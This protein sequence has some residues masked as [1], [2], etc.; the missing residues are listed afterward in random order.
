MSSIK[1]VEIGYKPKVEKELIATFYMEP[2]KV[3]FHE[4]ADA[5]AGES[6]IGS[7]TEL[8]T[9]SPKTAV[10]LKARVFY[11]NEKK[12]IIK[13][14][15]PM[16]LFEKGSIPQL[17]SSLGGNIFGMKA[18]KNLRWQDIE[19]PKKYIDSFMGPAFGI[20]GIRKI[21]KVK[22]R[23]LLGS[24]IKPKVGLSALAQ[25][26]LSA[27]VWLNGI[28]LI[29]DDENLTDM[30]FNRF[31]DRVKKVF[32]WKRKVEKET[33]QEKLYACNITAT[34]D[35]MLRRAKLVKKYGGRCVMI[36]LVSVGLDNVQYLR[37][38]K[39]GLIIHGHRAGHAMFT[40]YK[41]HGMSMLVLAKL[42][43]L[44][45]ID[46]LHTGTV[47]G[48][49]EGNEEEVMTVNNL[50]KEDWAA[51]NVV[52]EDW[53]NIKPVMPIAS[54]GLHPGLLPKLI[55][56]LGQDLIVNFGAGIHGHPDGSAAGARACYQ[57]AEAISKG[58]DL[59]KYAE[60]HVE[61]ARA[62]EYWKS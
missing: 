37:K 61:L 24:I 36:D 26:K 58:I 28:D 30:A 45:G 5:V 31:E 11:I 3:K 10:R 15:Y 59:K 34:P 29:K 50:L 46:Q 42:S 8:K 9:L 17:L 22:N 52:R 19:F 14:A 6:S 20:E 62:L 32:E 33:K 16:D 13:I 25:A 1:F 38:Q 27:V 21:L 44:A 56:I 47:V 49:M 41:K 51:Y 55:E 57:A 53:S 40:R 12:K 60:D 48:K 4:A 39:L 2:H 35:E 43:R 54:G 18:V 7:W 23:V